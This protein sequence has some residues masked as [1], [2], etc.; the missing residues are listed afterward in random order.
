MRLYRLIAAVFVCAI[1]APGLLG[2][3][4]PAGPERNEYLSQRVVRVFDF[5]ERDRG[6]YERL[7]QYW[8]LM[9]GPS[10]PIYTADRTR[11]DETHSLSGNYSLM[12]DLNGGSAGLLCQRGTIAAVPG[13]DYIITVAV[14]T[15]RLRHA[16]ARLSGYF[17]DQLGRVIESSRSSSKLVASN[18]Q[19]TRLEMRLSG[20]HADAAWTVL[21]MEVLQ[22]SEFEPRQLDVHELYP[23]DIAGRVWFDDLAVFQLPRIEIQSA[24]STNVI[25]GERPVLNL[26]VRD[27]TGEPLRVEAELYDHVG[28]TIDS[29]LRV[30]DGRRAPAWEWRPNLPRYGWYWVDLKVWSGQR[31]V[32]RRSTAFIWL[33]E[34]SGQGWA[35]SHRFGLVAEGLSPGQR[36]MLPE[37]AKRIGTGSIIL[38]VWRE[39]MT[40]RQMD[41]L[42][43]AT[44]P[45]IQQL[46]SDGQR[47][48][49]S[50][51]GVPQALAV[52]ART[53][54]DSPIAL[55][56][57]QPEVWQP[58]LQAT[59][60]RYGQQVSRWQIGATGSVEAFERERLAE[61][62][63]QIRRWYS[64]LVPDVRVTL[65]W[66]ADREL[67]AAAVSADA[68]T[69]NVPT[70]VRPEH[71]SAYATQWRGGE[72]GVSL[73]LETLD[74]KRF[75]H[76]QRVTDFALR[77]VSAWGV[78]PETIYVRAPWV[79][80][81]TDRPTAVPDPVL[82]V[83]TNL[84]ERLG[85]RRFVARMRLMKGV[86]CHVL[87]GPGGGALVVWN[88]LAEEENPMID[89][90]LGPDPKAYDLWGNPVPVYEREGRHVMAIGRA[91]VVIEGIDANL[92]RFRATMRF[93]PDFVES[94]AK[95]HPVSLKVSN[96]WRRS[97]SG[98]IRLTGLERWGVQPRLIRFQIPSDSEIEVPMQLAMPISAIAGEKSMTA[99]V[100]LEAD[101]TYDIRVSV[102]LTVGLSGIELNETLVMQPNASGK[103][104]AVITMLVTNRGDKAENF[105]A[106]AQ[107]PGR[108]G[109]QRIVSNLKPGQ[110]MLK[111]FRFVDAT[112]DLSGQAIRVGIRQMDGPSMLNHLVEVP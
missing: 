23:R 59:A 74:T 25:R 76:E 110:T 55:L 42:R 48:T 1:A 39:E 111:R 81:A 56:S 102:P 89:M 2:Q 67:T 37:M 94:Q 49:L 12:V 83:Y 7:P 103:K 79:A 24:E 72:R 45:M 93:D 47:L 60:V 19:W 100:R 86:E 51:A 4:E 91:P 106:F 8:Y 40:A 104:D 101:E 97:I 6:N 80:G 69:M 57:D 17:T 5:D 18:D 71:L 10:Y 13:A 70:S 96:P 50:L 33:N 14:R 108:A 9:R 73:V 44:D 77:L 3:S 34:T 52:L 31:M 16:R 112:S 32:G 105:Y 27:L 87:D 68:L 65:P 61:E 88:E 20:D 82:A 29:Q 78:Q 28:N 15:E 54:T 41:G 26:N 66:A 84:I 21:R 92:A 58:Y 30:L 109:Q 53:D 22:P 90:Y 36:V 43:D 99:N 98:Q 35:E 107:A 95:V 46:V 63:A 75:N 11:L 85:E 62:Y 38:D 64:S